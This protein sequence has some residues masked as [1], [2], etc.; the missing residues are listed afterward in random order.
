MKTFNVMLTRAYRVTIEA[1]DEKS[2]RELAEFFIGDPEDKSTE[3][4]Q[5]QYGFNIQEIE[6]TMNEAIETGEVENT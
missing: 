5:A 2:A 3:K 1:E 4:D 6:M